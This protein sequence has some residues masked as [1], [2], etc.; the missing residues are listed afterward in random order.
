MYRFLTPSGRPEEMTQKISC[1]AVLRMFAARRRRMKLYC[2]RR[3]QGR[4]R[5]PARS[6]GKA[7]GGEKHVYFSAG[8]YCIPRT[9]VV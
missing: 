3:E 8:G 6:E 4:L 5:G 7:G 1:A 2:C 9:A